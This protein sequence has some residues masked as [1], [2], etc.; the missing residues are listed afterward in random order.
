MSDRH[1]HFWN[2]RRAVFGSALG[3]AFFAALTFVMAAAGY[4]LSRTGAARTADLTGHLLPALGTLGQLGEATLKSHTAGLQFVLARDEDGMKAR[5]GEA[6]AQLKLA[7]E[8]IARLESQMPDASAA[9]L[10]EQLL[11]SI[12]GYGTVAVKLQALLRDSDFD[13]A[14]KVLDGDLARAYQDV[15]K[16]L[17][18]VNTH[19]A[20]LSAGN[21][22][23]TQESLEKS[24]K[25]SVTL[26]SVIVGLSVVAVGLVF[27]VGRRVT[28]R[29]NHTAEELSTVSSRIATEAAGLDTSSTE[30][31]TG[32]SR[33]AASIEE[34]S[35]S[36][37]EMAG[38]TASNA[39]SA[40]KARDL[41]AAAREAADAGSAD[42]EHMT[43]AMEDIRTSATGISAIIKTIDEIA[44]QTNILAL[45]AAVEAARAGEAG[46]GFAV[47]AEEVRNLAQR[48]ANAARE[49]TG[50]IEDAV[51]KAQRGAELS[52][53]VAAGLSDVVG[54]AR[55]VDALV[56]N[57]AGTAQEQASG[58][59]EL[60]RAMHEINNVTQATA[61]SA[62]HGAS[63]ARD[64]TAHAALLADSVGSLNACVGSTS[65]LAAAAPLVS[66]QVSSGATAH[67]SARAGV[68][69]A[70]SARKSAVST[71]ARA[72]QPASIDF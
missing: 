48:S 13:G 43:R 12:R 38:M 51:A 32:A 2:L 70:K 49:T 15:E 8:L 18:A 53:K 30:L 68:I 31:S 3:F 36:L 24:V 63:G 71:P 57:I 1:S 28:L 55:E 47:V 4:R 69:A 58:I 54:K 72:H 46:M 44:F 61:A 45:N 26:G 37:E 27:F 25:I 35:A 34:T 7:E 60:K 11:A 59:N 29:F 22:R 42:M 41:A 39:D 62:E 6:A 50:R 66:P 19:V 23:A 40:A 33:Q 67:A 20:D 14:M 65:G 16:K 5:A 17:A 10:L 56:T 9:G 64:L 21:G 52:A